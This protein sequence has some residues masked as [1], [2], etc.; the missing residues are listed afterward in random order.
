MAIQALQFIYDGIVIGS[1]YALVGLGVVIIFRTTNV[2]NFAQGAIAT[3]AGYLTWTLIERWGL[4]YPVAALAAMTLG[5]LLGVA[6]GALVT[7]LLHRTTMLEKSVATLGV[8][9]A[10]GW[11]N[12][13]LFTDQTQAIPRVLNV[14]IHLGDL[15]IG[16]HG[17]YVIGIAAVAVGATFFLLERTRLGLAMRSLSQ[18]EV[19]ARMYGVSVRTVTIAAFGIASALGALSGVLVGSFIQVDHSIMTTILIQ[20][21]AALVLGGFGST[22][23][24]IVGGLILGISSSLVA[25]FLSSA[26]KNTFVFAIILLV[27]IVRPHGLLGKAGLWVS[28]GG[29][30]S[31]A[32]SLPTPGDWRRPRWLLG[33]AIGVVAIVALPWIPH[34][35][36]LVTYSILLATAAVVVSLTL[37][38]GYIGE[39]SLGHGALVTLG[40]YVAAVLAREM[41]GIPFPIVLVVGALGAGALGALLGWVTLRLVGVYFAIA[42]LALTFVV[43]EVAL[44]ARGITGGA[45]GAQVAAPR[46]LGDPLTS[47]LGVYLLVAAAFILLALAAATLLRTRWGRYWVAIR[48]APTA[49]AAMGVAVSRH[50]VVAFA[51]SSAIAGFGGV[52]LGT[53]VT[54]VGPF[55]FGLQWSI[56]LILAVIVGGSG[57]IAG[58]LFGAAFVVLVPAALSRTAGLSDLVFGISLVA[59]FVFAP[60][61]LHAVVSNAAVWLRTRRFGRSNGPTAE[62]DDALG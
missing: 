47:D 56:T 11:A 55:D 23:G 59:V 18:D 26:F 34:P 21:F 29:G 19:T 3:T 48:D 28:E 40:A 5:G 2:L 37:F 7:I 42:T 60:G 20:S 33:A 54:H 38:M 30:A 1:L 8:S 24:A 46:L 36:P 51:V 52:L 16:G 12:R 10:L 43:T 27:L 25:G 58:A 17:L 62:P 50:K 14:Q 31:R 35:F 44:Q 45:V 32:P 41:A 49:A 9:L 6:L 57:S 39:F 53:V 13:E 4:P 61:G 22:G 15:V